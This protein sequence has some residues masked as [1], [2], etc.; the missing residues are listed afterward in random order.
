MAD[1]KNFEGL[2]K[3]LTNY[4]D[5]DFSIYLRRSFASS[6][7]YSREMLGKPIIGIA[8]PAGTTAKIITAKQDAG[9]LVTWLIQD[10]IRVDGPMTVICIRLSLIQVA[11]FI[12][13]VHSKTAAL[14]GFQKLLRN[15]EVRINIGPVQWQD[16]ACFDLK[17]FHVSNVII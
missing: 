16:Y 8:S 12:E 4:G 7:G 10:K 13:Q 1:D 3:G 9:I 14:D 2:A 15:D 17:C 11:V 5:M 6:M